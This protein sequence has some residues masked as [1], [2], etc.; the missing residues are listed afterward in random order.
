MTSPPT[1]E[2]YSPAEKLEEDAADAGLVA[3]EG[4]R[5]IEI[6][7]VVL[8]GLLVCPPLAILVVVVVL[9]LLVMALVLGLVAAV[10]STPYLLV[11]H[12]RGHDRGHL[13]LLKHRL[14]LAGRA[15]FDLAPHRIV[16][17]ARKVDRGR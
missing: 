4:L 17:D 6:G 16:A 12:F 15:L 7:G 9:P 14:R 8:L 11:H 10:I 1:H 2:P 3:A 5:A 13:S